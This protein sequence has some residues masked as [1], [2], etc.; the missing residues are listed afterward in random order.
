V[1]MGR[2]SN[3][4]QGS[5]VFELEDALGCKVMRGKIHFLLKWKDYGEEHNTW[6]PEDNLGNLG[7][8]L[9]KKMDEMKE[10][11]LSERRSSVG[12][13]KQASAAAK[14]RKSEMPNQSKTEASPSKRR[15]RAET[16]ASDSGTMHK[17][18]TSAGASHTTVV[19]SAAA[20]DRSANTPV[21]GDA[22]N[23]SDV[24]VPKD[25]ADADETT[26]DY[27][28]TGILQKGSAVNDIR[29]VCVHKTTASSERVHFGLQ[30]ARKI[31]PQSLLTFL[32]QRLQFPQK[33]AA[34]Q[35][36]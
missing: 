9:K 5:D 28:V 21:K 26:E 29:V 25:C 30:E 14:R 2:K 3:A 12:G 31:M 36:R 1:D 8:V 7:D 11:V 32:L 22:I 6:E 4:D 18:V 16:A 33:A 10:R 17:T 15:R 23:G 13:I 19:K 34:E 27:E 20:V 35:Q 24:P